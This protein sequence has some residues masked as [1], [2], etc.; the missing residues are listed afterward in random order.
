MRR[1][2]LARKVTVNGLGLHTGEWVNVFL[3]PAQ[4][5]EGIVFYVRDGRRVVHIPALTP[6]VADTRR[7]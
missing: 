3:H 4:E 5:G 6:F 7:R 1:K 2:T